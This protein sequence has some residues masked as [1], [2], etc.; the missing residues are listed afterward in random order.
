MSNLWITNRF[1]NPVNDS[2]T[3]KYIQIK[4]FSQE[5]SMTILNALKN[6][7]SSVYFQDTTGN[8]KV[9]STQFI[10]QLLTKPWDNKTSHFTSL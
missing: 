7:D 5:D 9:N 2:I 4:K 10:N 3:G 6:K 1:T 8:I